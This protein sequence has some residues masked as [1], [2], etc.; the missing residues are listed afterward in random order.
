M[1]RIPQTSS[2]IEFILPYVYIRTKRHAAGTG[3][4]EIIRTI[5]A[6]LRAALFDL[7]FKLIFV[8]VIAPFWVYKEYIPEAFYCHPT[9]FSENSKAFPSLVEFSL[10]RVEKKADSTDGRVH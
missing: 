7:L 6:N 2:A 4:T 9:P 1:V 10:R 8:M 5:F 3:A